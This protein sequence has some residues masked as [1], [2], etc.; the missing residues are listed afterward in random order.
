MLNCCCCVGWCDGAF[1]GAFVSEFV[2]AFVGALLVRWLVRCF[3][4]TT[5]LI[6]VFFLFDVIVVFCCI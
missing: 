5:F 1:V 6:I 4:Q 3:C 2:G